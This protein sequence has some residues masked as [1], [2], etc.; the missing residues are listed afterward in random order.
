MRSPRK[1]GEG[2][3]AFPIERLDEFIQAFNLRGGCDRPNSLIILSLRGGKRCS[4]NLNANPK[5]TIWTFKD[6]IAS[7]KHKLLNTWSV[8]ILTVLLQSVYH[9]S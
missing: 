1:A 5:G 9:I 7:P 8:M 6:A 2:G 4:S 3:A